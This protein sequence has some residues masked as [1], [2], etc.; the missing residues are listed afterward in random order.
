MTVNRIAN[1]EHPAFGIASGNDLVNS[2]FARGEHFDNNAF[3]ADQTMCAGPNGIRL[4]V[5]LAFLR[6]IGYT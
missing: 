2:P 1:A 5:R 6:V 4:Q 3:I